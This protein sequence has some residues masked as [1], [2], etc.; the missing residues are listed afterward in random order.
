MECFSKNDKFWGV[1]HTLKISSLVVLLMVD[2]IQICTITIVSLLICHFCV[3]NYK[4]LKTILVFIAPLAYFCNAVE[5]TLTRTANLY[6]ICL[7]FFL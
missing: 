2:H 1:V 6:H 7:F 4:H 3:I 5:P